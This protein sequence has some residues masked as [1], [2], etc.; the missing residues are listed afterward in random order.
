[1]APRN[2]PSVSCTEESSDDCSKTSFEDSCSDMK[3]GKGSRKAHADKNSDEYRKRR[4]RNNI[5]VKKSRNKSKLKTQQTLER[6]NELKKEN[7]MLEAKIALLV[8]ELSF[9][10][11]LFLAHAGNAHGQ[12]LAHTD[13]SF[14]N[15][16]TEN[17]FD[18][19]EQTQNDIAI[20]ND[21]KYTQNSGISG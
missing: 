8:K 4:E 5:A 13:L 9:L 11:D 10:K 14:L 6:V 15:E 3:G 19:K 16:T 12:D 7:E 21:H 2:K 1:M 18:I 20:R 17:K